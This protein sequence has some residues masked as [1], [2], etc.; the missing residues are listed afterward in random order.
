MRPWAFGKIAPPY[1]ESLLFNLRQAPGRL[2]GAVDGLSDEEMAQAPVPG[3]WS[4]RRCVEHIVQ[5]NL[6]WTDILYE[7]V[8]PYH[9][10]LK[11]HVP[12][13]QQ[14]PMGRIT[15]SVASA[16]QVMRLNH[17]EVIAFLEHLPEDSFVFEHPPVQW[18]VQAGIP[19]VIKESV[20]WGLSVHVD[21]HL[22]HIH[23]KRVALGK[24][25]DWMA[26]IRTE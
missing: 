7:A 8:C 17:A 24:G 4:T 26:A 20:N 2:R 11:Q 14:A 22:I 10:D 21:H 25:L 18:L 16:L 6:G 19:F 9:P 3:K 12:G 15:E 5:A 13:W 23:A 1:K